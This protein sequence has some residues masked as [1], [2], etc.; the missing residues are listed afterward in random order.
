MS[1]EIRYLSIK[2]AQ[3]PKEI[4]QYRVENAWRL[5][6]IRLLKAKK[7]LKSKEIKQHGAKKA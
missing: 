1:K 6:E 2:K 7:T 3:K 4:K 5:K